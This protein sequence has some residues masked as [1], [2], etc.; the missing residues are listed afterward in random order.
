MNIGIAGTGFMGQTHAQCYLK[1]AKTK[2]YAIAESNPDKQKIIKRNYPS[3]RIYNDVIEMIENKSIDIIDIC[4]P[5]QLH[6]KATIEA[7]NRGKHVLLEKPIALTLKEAHAIKKAAEKSNS[8]FMVAHVLRFWPSY[9]VIHNTLKKFFD[10]EHIS[11][12]Y[13]SRFNQLPLW[14]ENSWIL[15]ETNSGGLVIDLMIHDIDFINWNFGKVKKVFALAI[16]NKNNFAIQVLA[17]LKMLNGTTA[18]I[19]G[20]Y[21]NPEGSGLSSQMRIYST[22]SLIEMYSHENII[23]L[24]SRKKTTKNIAIPKKNGYL[25]EIKYFLKC[26]KDN[27]IPDV[28]TVN[29][30][31]E[32]LKVSLAL[33]DSLE[34]NHW[35]NIN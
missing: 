6:T 30:A 27:K 12:I 11:E 24:N 18:Y 1:L 9:V 14:S 29:D 4:L 32:S 8:K 23:R 17:I 31:I 34:L 26:I 25:E 16:Y 10:D 2:L 13:A 3:I 28:I 7:L 21:L 19:E 33:K 15:N 35:I 5:T 20:G 22:N